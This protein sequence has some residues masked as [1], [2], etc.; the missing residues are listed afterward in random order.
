MKKLFLAALI[1]LTPLLASAVDVNVN[2]GN[3]RVATTG[4][5]MSIATRITGDATTVRAGKSITPATAKA[6]MLAIAHRGRPRKAIAEARLT[7][8]PT[9]N[10]SLAPKTKTA[11]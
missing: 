10:R 2:L 6:M 7:A 8:G 4:M 3:V 5:A 9:V 1:G 11:R